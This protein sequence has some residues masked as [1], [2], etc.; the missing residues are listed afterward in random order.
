MVT[1]AGSWIA[2]LNRVL[3]IPEGFSHEHRSYGT[4]DMRILFMPQDVAELLPHHPAALVVS[5]LAREAMLAL[6][7]P[8]DRSGGARDRLRRVIVDELTAAPE[9]PLHLPEPK[10]DRLRAV[11]RLVEKDLANSAT[12]GDLGRRVG[13]SERTLSRLFR[14]ETGMSYPQWRTEL[15]VH[16]ALL[17]LAE[18]RAVVDTALACGW[19]NPSS[20]IEAFTSLVGQ[21]PGAYSRSLGSADSVEGGEAVASGQTHR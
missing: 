17:M 18:G 12:L 3:W 11:A 5:A 9:Q 21:T 15:R 6:T 8:A 20:F 4:T 2:P 14:G 16:R 7:G 10:D 13:A 1:D 19:A